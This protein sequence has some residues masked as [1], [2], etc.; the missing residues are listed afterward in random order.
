M[1][2]INENRWKKIG[3]KL[4]DNV[5]YMHAKKN[6]GNENWKK[7]KIFLDIIIIINDGNQNTNKIYLVI[8]SRNHHVDTF[9]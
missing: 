3:K 5:K 6:Y 4:D 8:M 9:K 7:K 2:Y 1:S